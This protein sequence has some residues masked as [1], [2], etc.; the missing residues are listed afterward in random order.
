MKINYYLMKKNEKIIYVQLEYYPE[1]CI[2]NYIDIKI[3]KINKCPFQFLRLK[4]EEDQQEKIYYYKL[5][6]QA[7][8]S[9]IPY[10]YHYTSYWYDSML[11]CSNIYERN[12]D[13][14]EFLALCSNGVSITDDYWFLPEKK[15]YINFPKMMN[16]NKD[17]LFIPRTYEEIKNIKI[18]YD[19]NS[20]YSLK[21]FDYST[22][23]VLNYSI[24]DFCTYGYR[25]KY[26]RKE[27]NEFWLYK[28]TKKREVK[29]Y[30]KWLINIKKVITY[31]SVIVDYNII[32]N[33][34]GY[35]IKNVLDKNEILISGIDLFF[36]GNE[37]SY[38]NEKETIIN[39]KILS[40]EIKNTYIEI[41][42]MTQNNINITNI[43]FIFNKNENQITKIFISGVN[44]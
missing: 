10:I 4:N 43:H 32:Q 2:L 39:S 41:Q 30:L 25:Y 17:L 29:K 23:N 3:L 28:N 20:S 15:Y 21:E 22:K 31:Q 9:K 38:I 24:Y 16:P 11:H 6:F 42:N 44:Y 27:N 7:R 14:M 1:L 5:F 26:W 13:Y 18:N 36:L 19:N 40:T 8:T 12:F 35:K 37:N 34:E 33:K